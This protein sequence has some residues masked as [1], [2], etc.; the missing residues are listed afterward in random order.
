MGLVN[1][2]SQGLEGIITVGSLSDYASVSGKFNAKQNY[3]V[4]YID[5]GNADFAEWRLC[6]TR[7]SRIFALRRRWAQTR[8]LGHARGRISRRRCPIRNQTTR[9]GVGFSPNGQVY[10]T[11]N[12]DQQNGEVWRLLNGAASR[13]YDLTIENDKDKAPV[14]FQVISLDGVALA[15]T[16]NTS[17]TEKTVGGRFKPVPCPGPKRAG[18]LSEPVCATHLVMFPSSRAEIWISPAQVGKLKSASLV[19]RIY[20]HWTGW[21]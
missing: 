17:V 10:P 2:I 12:M 14:R 6:R 19:T 13:S 1:Q 11:I 3:A 18:R 20:T 9:M 7:K 8:G 15:P 16:A 4:R 5:V 21:G